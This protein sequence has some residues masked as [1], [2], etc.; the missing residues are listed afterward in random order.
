M[1]HYP[2][3]NMNEIHAA[4]AVNTLMREQHPD[5][6][7]TLAIVD[8]DGNYIF[9]GTACPVCTVRAMTG[10][11]IGTNQPHLDLNEEES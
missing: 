8:P 1:G 5:V 3:L 6:N 11:V 10:W 2:N 4:D 7:Y 9:C